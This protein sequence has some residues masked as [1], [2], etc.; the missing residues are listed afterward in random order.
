[1]TGT[2][3]RGV[4][5]LV[6]AGAAALVATMY[7]NAP[8]RPR[9]ADLLPHATVLPGSTQAITRP[10]T[11]GVVVVQAL[12][13]SSR[14]F[15]ALD[16]ALAAADPALRDRV[17]AERLPLLTLRDPARAARLAE[18][19][20][21]ARLRELALLQVAMSWARSD[22]AAA[23]HWAES[24]PDA[25][26]RDATITDISLALAES[27]PA[28]AVALRERFVDAG[29][30][31]PDNTLVNLAHQWAEQD[32]DAALA[33]ASAQ[34]PGAQRDQVLER[35]VFAQ[36]AAGAHEVAARLAD[37]SFSGEHRAEAMAVV[38]QQWALHDRAGALE[39]LDSLD[40]G[41]RLR[42]AHE[43]EPAH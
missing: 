37:T 1:M 24:L 7:A 28:R 4:T 8:A 38:A 19:Q 35:L 15:E 17:L 41:L 5:C 13:D 12:P 42:I 31:V 34:A 16:E 3:Y 9:P 10:A 21:D 33:W 32:F 39:W 30:T 26:E 36:A 25:Q 22:E 11:A 23:V 14:G 20:S 40:A 43:V 27:S 29:A 2:E 6:A 18:L